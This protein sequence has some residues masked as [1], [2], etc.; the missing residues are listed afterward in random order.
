VQIIVE[1]EGS[2][3]IEGRRYDTRK[4]LKMVGIVLVGH[5]V[6]LIVALA[7]GFIYERLS[8]A[9]DAERFTAP[10]ELFDVEGRQLHL[11]CTGNGSPTV[12]LEAGGASSSIQWCP[13]HSCLI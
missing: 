9:C 2:A 4:V 1:G 10:G 7:G 8:E 3:Q 12:L 11:W 6:L 5:I 13:V